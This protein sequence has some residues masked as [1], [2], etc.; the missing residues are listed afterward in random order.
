[1]FVKKMKEV[2]Q[3]VITKLTY[4]ASHRL[5]FSLPVF[6]ECRQPFR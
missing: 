2:W 6:F 5:D 3:R 1:M 4:D